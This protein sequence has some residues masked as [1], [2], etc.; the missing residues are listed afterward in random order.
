MEN[1]IENITPVQRVD[2]IKRNK[3]NFFTRV[4]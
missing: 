3:K 2:F 4:I 1:V